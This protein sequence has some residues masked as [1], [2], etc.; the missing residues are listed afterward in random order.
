[1]KSFKTFILEL[2][3]APSKF[4]IEY[5]HSIK[6]GP[7]SYTYRAKVGERDIRVNFMR[8]AKE[9]EGR[10]VVSIDTGDDPTQNNLSQVFATLKS[11]ILNFRKK[12]E[13]EGDLETELVILA[14]GPKQSKIG[15]RLVKMMRAGSKQIQT[16]RGAS[17]FSII[18]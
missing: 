14:P 12:R 10:F 8:D 18:L 4:W 17:Y 7:A 13:E 1:M 9:P 11:I 2:F 15:N 16:S 5:S 3:D 6:G